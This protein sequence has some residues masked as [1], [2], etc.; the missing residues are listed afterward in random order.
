MVSSGARP[1]LLL[2]RRVDAVYAGAFIRSI[3]AYWHCANQ[4]F[5]FWFYI[6][7]K[8]WS[9][10][11]IIR[12]FM[13]L[14]WYLKQTDYE[15]I[16]KLTAAPNIQ[17][18]TKSFLTI[19]TWR[20]SP[21]PS[22]TAAR[23]LDAAAERSGTMIFLTRHETMSVTFTDGSK[24]AEKKKKK[25]PP[26]PR[27]AVVAGGGSSGVTVWSGHMCECHITLSS[28]STHL[29]TPLNSNSTHPITQV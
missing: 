9:A 14:F 18:H 11:Q 28:V 3:L 22:A 25:N 24:S 1:D 6:I 21:D 10:M 7:L 29:R 8:I 27:Q 12:W 26:A 16:F 19:K 15:V 4:S 17:R 20:I 13:S 23:T 5:W 2:E